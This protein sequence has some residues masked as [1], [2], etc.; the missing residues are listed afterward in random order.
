MNFDY[1]VNYWDVSSFDF[2]NNDFSSSNG[3]FP[4]IRQEQKVA[5]VKGW[6]HAAAGKKH[7]V[8]SEVPWAQQANVSNHKGY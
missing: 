8:T 7:K 2:E 1:S 5:P 4:E 3:V 6:L